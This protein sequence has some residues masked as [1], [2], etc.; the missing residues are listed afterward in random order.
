MT[1]FHF[2]HLHLQPTTNRKMLIKQ[3]K[4]SK[5]SKL[6]LLVFR[7]ILSKRRNYGLP[8]QSA[9][10]RYNCNDSIWSDSENKQQKNDL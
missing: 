6:R 9:I 10:N 3:K 5:N 8:N 7:R 1:L 4:R 2:L